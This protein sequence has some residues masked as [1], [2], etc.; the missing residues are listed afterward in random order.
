M[1]RINIP[2]FY[3]SDSG[4]P[5]WGDAQ[6]V[7]DG[8]NYVVIDGYCQVGTDRLIKRLKKLNI[9][10]PN[11]YLSHVHWDHYCGLRKI[12]NDGWFHPASFNCQDPDS[13]GDVSGDVRGEKQ[14]LRKI[15]S[16]ARARGIKVNYLKDGD[17][18]TIGDIDF[19]VYQKTYSY[20]GNSDAYLNDGSLCFWFKSIGYWTS[21]DGPQK[22]ADMCEA[23]GARPVI[24]KIPHHGNNCPR[25]QAQGMK[26]LGAVYCWDN[27]YSTGITDFLQYGR[28]RCIE[29]GIQYINCHGDINII[30]QGGYVAIYKDFKSYKYKCIYKGKT[31]LKQP[32][33]AAVEGVLRGT[34]GTGN[35]RI[36]ALIDAGFYPIATQDK[37]TEI[38]NLVRG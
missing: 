28:G 36:T 2:G 14:T 1:I 15:I 10:N 27:D 37:V 32:T 21:G 13:I 4:G 19:Y 16:E 33:I 11:L 25:L 6:I 12:I 30:A 9:K 35:A 24:F 22:I 8:K 38:I 29:A 23:K 7:D 18:V 5:R 31:R 20:T 26:R 34:Y 3:S 17:H